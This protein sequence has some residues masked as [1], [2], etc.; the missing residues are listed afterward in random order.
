MF[1]IQRWLNLVLDLLVAALAVIIIS[2]AVKFRSTMR[3]GQIGIALNVVL[4]FNAALLRLIEMWTLLET[5]FG[6]IARLMTLEE[7]TSP[8]DKLGE[9]VVQP[10]HWPGQGT[11]EFRDV[12]A[13]YG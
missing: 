3:G 10:E 4:I 7:K 6:A 8:E 5:T 2:L 9:D 1:C 11:I 12:I 13:T